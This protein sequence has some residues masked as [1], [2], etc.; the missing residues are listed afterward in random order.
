MIIWLASYPKS[1]NTWLRAMIASYFYTNDGIFNFNVLEQ[2]DQFPSFTHFENYND[3]FE[4]PTSTTKYWFDAQT[5][6]QNIT[7][8]SNEG[9]TWE[10]SN[11]KFINNTLSIEFREAFLPRRGRINCSLNDDGKWRWFGTQFIITEN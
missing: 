1:G 10:K 7:C 2:I 6:I 8:Y 9:D 11:T 5:N 4:R 3:K